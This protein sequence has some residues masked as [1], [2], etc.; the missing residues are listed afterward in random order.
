MGVFPLRNPSETKPLQTL[1]VAVS[2]HCSALTLSRH[3]Y[4]NMWLIAPFPRKSSTRFRSATV[5]G[6]TNGS[7][8]L[9]YTSYNRR[10]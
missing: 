9:R 6:A 3:S 5:C 8:T 7:A 1:S 2:R 10:V 4:G